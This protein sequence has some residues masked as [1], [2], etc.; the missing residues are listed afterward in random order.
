[1]PQS[2]S[3]TRGAAA[4]GVLT[5]LAAG[6]AVLASP[7]TAGT[8]ETLSYTCT[9]AEL[10]TFPVTATHVSGNPL[11]YGGHLD[12]FSTVTLPESVVQ[13][14]RSSGVSS[15]RGDI[16]L[17]MELAGVRIF[18]YEIIT[19]E[20]VPDSGPMQLVGKGRAVTEQAAE[21]AQAGM[22]ESLD[23]VDVQG[24]SD[25]SLDLIGYRV[26]AAETQYDV[27]CGL[28]YGQD[29]RAGL[30]EV[31]KAQTRTGVR[32]AYDEKTNEVV[33]Y[34]AVRTLESSLRAVGAIRVVLWRNGERID[35]DTVPVRSG[36][37]RLRTKA[38][39]KGRYRLVATYLGNLS[40]TGSR[41]V[42]EDYS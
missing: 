10:G 17:P 5:L 40:F 28:D 38:P 20:G 8:S 11:V 13:D 33:S 14:L 29:L 9:S 15:V 39:E 16:S 27:D 30:V 2:R 34:A 7:A 4:V 32:L 24:G 3:A 25:L 36:V 37:E 18:P 19:E 35:S 23:L 21:E 31:I 6:G 22:A 42:T 26:D 12:M 41:G 1:M